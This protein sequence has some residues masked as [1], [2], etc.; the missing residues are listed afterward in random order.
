MAAWQTYRKL[1]MWLNILHGLGR[2][3]PAVRRVIL[4]DEQYRLW[5]GMDAHLPIGLQTIAKNVVTRASGDICWDFN[6]P[7]L[8]A[9]SL[10]KD[11]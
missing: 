9:K 11:K 10:R 1:F 4:Q 5:T 6:S 7:W 3:Y 8:R 2:W